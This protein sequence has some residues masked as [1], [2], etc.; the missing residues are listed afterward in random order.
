MREAS[1]LGFGLVLML[2]AFNFNISKRIGWSSQGI[3]KYKDQR[4]SLTTNILNGIKSIKYFCWEGTFYNKIMAIRKNEFAMIA[5]SK[6]LDAFCVFIWA[7]TSILLTVVTFLVFSHMGYNIV[8]DNIFTVSFFTSH[9][10]NLLIFK[11]I[12]LFQMMILPLNDLPW[13]IGGAMNAVHSY[14]R[15]KAFLENNQ[16]TTQSECISSTQM[17]STPASKISSAIEVKC[18]LA[19]WPTQM[20]NE[21]VTFFLK[22][23]DCKIQTGLLHFVVGN[24]SSGKT[25]FL[26]LLMKELEIPDKKGYT[27]VCNGS[28][29]YV[30][31]NSWLQRGSI[32]VNSLFIAINS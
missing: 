31:Q 19:I 28:I 20:T 13:T 14:K 22:N 11:T 25:A 30:S 12:G 8:Q 6:Y 2:C 9:P 27:Y 5:A 32:K 15:V 24:V 4:V 21:S 1:A 17:Q 26:Q 29:A 10:I 7:T 16:T 23:V 3:A 18:A